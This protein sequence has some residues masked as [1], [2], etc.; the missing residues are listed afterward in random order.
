MAFQ[1]QSKGVLTGCSRW[2]TSSH[3]KDADD[4]IYLTH[5]SPLTLEYRHLLGCFFGHRLALDEPP[6]LQ[7]TPQST[8]VFLP[9][10]LNE[11][12]SG[13]R[14]AVLVKL[15]GIP[16]LQELFAGAILEGS[17]DG[18]TVIDNCIDVAASKPTVRR[19]I[20]SILQA[21]PAEPETPI[22]EPPA[23]DLESR[24]RSVADRWRAETGMFSFAYQWEKHPAYQEIIAMGKQV[25]P[26]ILQ[27]LKDRPDHWFGALRTLTGANP[28]PPEDLGFFQKMADAWLAWGQD[29][30]YIPQTDV[31]G[32]K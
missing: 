32:T 31:P 30:G 19:Q 27:E 3:P 20:E 29:K 16:Y 10:R 13:A 26:L 5:E 14:T 9:I 23:N 28:V 11:L 21:V 2:Y 12:P 22:A 17:L 1:L 6:S 8:E 25:V 15:L 7:D 18:S 4:E 24:F